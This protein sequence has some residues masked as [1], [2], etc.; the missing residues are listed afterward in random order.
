MEKINLEVNENNLP[1]IKLYKTYGFQ[2]VGKRNKYY[3]DG[4]N[5]ILMT[6]FV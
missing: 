2:T 1:A 3:K 5:A 4:G 6:Y